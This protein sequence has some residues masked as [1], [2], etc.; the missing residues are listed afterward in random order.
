MTYDAAR[1]EAQRIRRESNYT[2]FACPLNTPAGWTVAE[3]LE[4]MNA[5]PFAT[6]DAAYEAAQRA[7]VDLRAVPLVPRFAADGTHAVLITREMQAE[8]LAHLRA[9]KEGLGVSAPGRRAA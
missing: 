5:E 7:V 4:E 6:L 8:R 9:W 3:S 2:A 1:L